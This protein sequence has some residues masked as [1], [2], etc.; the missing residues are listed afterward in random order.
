M[1]SMEFLE[2]C[3]FPF[4]LIGTISSSQVLKLESDAPRQEP[5]EWCD[6]AAILRIE[7]PM[8]SE[9]LSMILPGELEVIAAVSG[10]GDEEDRYDGEGGNDGGYGGAYI[11]EEG[12]YSTDQTQ[13]PNMQMHLAQMDDQ[14]V[15]ALL[16]NNILSL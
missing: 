15:A 12:R 2:S 10:E 4:A 5:N 8:H 16:K 11:E 9:G 13:H 6:R 14:R 7:E 1:D 3:Q